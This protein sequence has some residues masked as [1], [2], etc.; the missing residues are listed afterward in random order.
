[1]YWWCSPAMAMTTKLLG[2]LGKRTPYIR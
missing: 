2:A 1:M